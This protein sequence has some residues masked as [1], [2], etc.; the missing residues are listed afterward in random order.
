[1]APIVPLWGPFKL[2]LTVVIFAAP[3]IASDVNVP[4]LVMLVCAA[5]DNVPVSIAPAFPIVPALTLT[6]VGALNVVVL[7]ADNVVKAPEFAVLAPIVP[8]TGPLT[9]P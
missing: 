4:K 7:E 2:P 9:A 5:V 8:F 6:A 3:L 1:M